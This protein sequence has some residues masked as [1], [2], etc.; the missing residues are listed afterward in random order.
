VQGYFIKVGENKQ[1]PFLSKAAAAA[2]AKI[3]KEKGYEVKVVQQ[4]VS[5]SAMM[6]ALGNPEAEVEL[7]DDLDFD[8]IFGDDDDAGDGDGDDSDDDSDAGDD[9][10]GDEDDSDDDNDS[11]AGDDDDSDEAPTGVHGWFKSWGGG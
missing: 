9:D 8:A 11:D 3:L 2:E 5:E 6:E 1:G 4:T 7:E 10:A